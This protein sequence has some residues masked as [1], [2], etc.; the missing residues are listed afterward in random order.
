MVMSMLGSRKVNKKGRS[1]GELKTNKR[2]KIASQFVP[3][4]IEMLE[5]PAWRTLSLSGRRILD[6]L[7]IEHGHHGAVQNGRLPV[8]FDDF[9]KFGIERHCIAPGIREVEALGFAEITQRGGAGNAHLRQPNMFR[10]T[11]LHKYQT[12]ENATNEWRRIQ[13][14]EEAEMLARNARRAKS[15]KQK[16]N[17]G[18]P[19][20][21]GAENPTTNCQFH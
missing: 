10:L 6:R 21:I 4:T 7:E 15:R 5:S 3:H 19:T 8:T 9:V 17:V 16:T 20:N 18:K 2:L 11:Y 1:I 14:I 12:G 13:T